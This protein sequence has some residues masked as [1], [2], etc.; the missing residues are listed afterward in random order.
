M[1]KLTWLATLI[2]LLAAVGLA[3][4]AVTINGAGATFPYPIYAQWAHKYNS[5]TGLQVNYQA[6]GSGGGIAQI[7]AGTVDF[8][9]SS[10]STAKPS[11]ISTWARSKNGTTRPSRASTLT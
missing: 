4:A 7:K 8:G 10:S 11:A 5:L 9:A 6:I 2:G 3:Q 1:K